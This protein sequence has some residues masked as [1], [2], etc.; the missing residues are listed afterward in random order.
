MRFIRRSRLLGLTLTGVFAVS[1]LGAGVAIA[2]DG[3]ESRPAANEDGSRHP[4]VH[5][6][7]LKGLLHSIV[8]N[9]ALEPGTFREGFAAGK[10]INE[11]LE[12]NGVDPAAI[13]AEVLADLDAKLDELV[14]G[15]QLTQEEAD[16]IYAAA[17]EHLPTLMERVPDRDGPHRRPLRRL[18]HGIRGMIG[19]AAE[20]LGMERTELAERLRAG[21]T[22]AEVATEQG[23]DIQVVSAAILA[24][25]NARV[26]E[27]VANGRIEEARADEIKSRIATRTESFLTEGRPRGE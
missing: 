13:Q 9:S 14:A 18:L 19:S 17:E 25:A 3:G 24:D 11:V 22:V 1:A 23:I 20:A 7:V 21:E 12:E 16:R 4:H 27:A 6:R 10:S 5:H 2:Q 26:D 15:G 8:E